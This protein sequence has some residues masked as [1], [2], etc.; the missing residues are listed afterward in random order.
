MWLL[1]IQIITWGWKKRSYPPFF[2][3]GRNVLRVVRNV[4]ACTIQVFEMNCYTFIFQID[5]KNK[6]L[7]RL[8]KIWKQLLRSDLQNVWNGILNWIWGSSYSH[9]PF[10]RRR[11]ITRSGAASGKNRDQ[12]GTKHRVEAIAYCERGGTWQA[13][14]ENFAWVSISHHTFIYPLKV[15]KESTSFWAPPV[16]FS[17]DRTKDGWTS[18]CFVNRCCIILQWGISGLTRCATSVT[19]RVLLPFKLHTI[20]KLCYFWCHLF[21]L[22]KF[23]LLTWQSLKPSTIRSTSFLQEQQ[24]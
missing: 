24:S 4:N 23:S 15:I 12:K 13:S 16:L 10:K 8:I 20:K 9:R 22:I 2:T 7:L 18:R 1:A 6:L 17:A 3:F 11:N 5:K 19:R 14:M 21:V